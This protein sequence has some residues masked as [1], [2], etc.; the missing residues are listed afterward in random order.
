MQRVESWLSFGGRQ[1]I[2]RHSSQSLGCEMNVSVYL[3]PQAEKKACPVLYWLSGLA[4]T[5][6]HFTEKAGA[7]RY[8][9]AHGI[10]LVAPD[11]S[12]R[13][14]GVADD[15]A[16][17]LGQ[18][19]GF[20]VNATQAPWAEHY[21]MYDYVVQEL[22]EWMA[23][24]FPVNG[25]QSVSGHSMGGHGAL[26]V[27]LKNPKL[28]KSVSAFSPLVA[29]GQM[30]WGEKAFAA[31]LGGGRES[32][33]AWEAAALV[34]DGHHF[35]CSILIDQGLADV[36]GERELFLDRFEALCEKQRQ[37][38]TLYRRKGYGHSYYFVASFI[39]EHIEYH[40]RALAGRI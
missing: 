28:Y 22:P 33:R 2:W 5:E 11:T 23:A 26:I 24:H 6:R 14:E 21:R 20:Y 30:P 32:W 40:A 31:Y 37:A 38:L 10:I 27:A 36:F 15:E 25:R 7:Q 4:C 35:P 17:D 34:E 12:P 18:G 13:G 3:P 19:A 8:A 29:P 39:G 9:A 1:E 16:Y